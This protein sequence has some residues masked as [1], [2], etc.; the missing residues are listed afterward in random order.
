MANW[1]CQS[2]LR[3]LGPRRKSDPDVCRRCTEVRNKEKLE[4][5]DIDFAARA[6]MR[7]LKKEIGYWPPR[8]ARP[9]KSDDDSAISPSGQP[10]PA[11]PSRD[12][13]GG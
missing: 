6:L 12:V 8:W 3:N 1:I 4:A 7:Q 2:C 11:P 10:L 13:G 9:P 5:R